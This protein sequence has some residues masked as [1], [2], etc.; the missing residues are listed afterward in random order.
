MSEHETQ[1]HN[2][3]SEA[4]TEANI[5]PAMTR[6]VEFNFSFKTP[7]GKD[8]KPAVDDLGNPVPKRPSFKAHLPVPTLDGVLAALRDEKQR[9]FVLDIISAEIYNAARI[10]VNDEEK[11][12][13]AAEDFD[14]AKLSL[15]FLANQPASERRGGGIP[16]ETWE[17]W[18]KDYIE[19]MPGA[20]GRDLEKVQNAAVLF[21]KKF[22]PVKTN[23]PVLK[24]LHEYLN[25]WAATTERLEEFADCFEFLDKKIETLLNADEASLLSNL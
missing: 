8:G 25:L 4:V 2:H 21:L 5:P 20:T 24:A 14:T 3:S 22:Q 6:N 10:Q 18:S 11:P 7:K 15:H 16:K 23:K 13:A 1:G 12:V 9:E 17:E 19:I